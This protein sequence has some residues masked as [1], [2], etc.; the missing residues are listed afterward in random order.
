[1]GVAAELRALAGVREAA[2]LM[3]TP[4]NQELLGVGRTGH[5]PRPRRPRPSDLVLAVDAESDAAAAAALAAARRP[6]W[7]SDSAPARRAVRAGRARSS[8]RCASCPTPTSR[9]SRC[10]GD[11]REAR[12][13][14]RAPPRPARVPLQ[15]QRPARRRD[16]AQAAGRRPSGCSAWAP[17]AAPPISAASASASPTS[18]RAAASAASPPPAPGCRRWPRRLAALGEGISHGIGVGGRDL[19]AEVGRRHDDLRARRARPR[20]RDR[21]D[22]VISKPPAPEVLPALEAALAPSASPSSSAA[23]GAA[24]RPEAPGTWVTTLEDAAGRGR[25]AACSGGRGRRG[26]FSD[27]AAVRARLAALAQ[28]PRRARTARPLHG[29]HARPRGAPAPRA[30]AGPV[31]QSRRPSGAPPDPRSRRRRVHARPPASR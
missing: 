15:R 10:P 17:T 19:S 26:A 9:R 8:R 12:G 20:S 1:M 4:A 6:I 28:R 2:A 30:A 3:G 24:A 23:L 22:R 11:V 5:A 16:R 13:P 29:R 27:P 7:R 14:H 25:G 21:G 18:C 31:R